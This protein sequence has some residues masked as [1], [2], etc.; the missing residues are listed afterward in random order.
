MTLVVPATKFSQKKGTYLN[1]LSSNK[2]DIILVVSGIAKKGHYVVMRPDIAIKLLERVNAKEA[3]HI[4]ETIAEI[5]KKVEKRGKY[6]Y[7]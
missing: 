1:M 6:F 5:N 4:I 3:K 7:E 2:E